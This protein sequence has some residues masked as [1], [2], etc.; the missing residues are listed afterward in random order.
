M[1]L[2]NSYMNKTKHISV[3]ITEEVKQ[4]LVNEAKKQNVTLTNLILRGVKDEKNKNIFS[5]LS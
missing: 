3:R 5:I 4:Q 2:I 1:T